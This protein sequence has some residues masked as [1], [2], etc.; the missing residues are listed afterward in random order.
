MEFSRARYSIETLW[1]PDTEAIEPSSPE[2]LV[3][4][5]EL[6]GVSSVPVPSQLYCKVENSQ[7]RTELQALEVPS[8]PFIWGETPG[9]RNVP[10]P[11]LGCWC[12]LSN[13]VMTNE[14]CQE[15]LSW[16]P[17][18]QNVMYYWS[19]YCEYMSFGQNFLHEQTERLLHEIAIESFGAGFQIDVAGRVK[20]MYSAHRKMRKKK[21][22]RVSEV[23]D[24]LGLKV[25]VNDDNDHEQARELCYVIM[26]AVQRLWKPVPQELD[27]YI[28]NPKDSGYQSL[29]TC[30][31]GPGWLIQKTARI[32]LHSKTKRNFELSTHTNFGYRAL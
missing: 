31:V 22:N 12:A 3:A 2:A 24:V 26:S 9:K 8:G 14:Q 25:V 10:E 17:S 7:G 6:Y 15:L 29:H 30:V 18:F 5:P 27:D 23:L 20:S 32:V 13:D 1:H 11:H 16:V 21:L 28:A 4:K 19:S